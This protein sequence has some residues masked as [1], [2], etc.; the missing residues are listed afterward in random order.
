M[1]DKPAPFPPPREPLSWPQAAFMIALLAF[2]AWE[3][4]VFF[5]R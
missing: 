5:G 2:L 4:W 1:T 3:T